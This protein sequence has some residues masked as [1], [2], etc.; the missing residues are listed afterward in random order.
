MPGL[1]ASR[2]ESESQAVPAS[3]AV[4]E[5]QAVPGLPEFLAGPELPE[6]L[7]ELYSR[8]FPVLW[9]HP[10]SLHCFR[11]SLFPSSL[12]FHRA[13]LYSQKFPELCFHPV[14]L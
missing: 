13:E 10:V 9:F 4:S 7:A 8:K 5:S 14:S 11:H 3:Q 2:A 1:P 6:F 12:W